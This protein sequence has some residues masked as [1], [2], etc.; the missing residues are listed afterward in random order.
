MFIK[1]QLNIFTQVR[2]R[3]DHDNGPTGSLQQIVPHG[4]IVGL[5]LHGQEA[6]PRRRKNEGN[7]QGIVSLFRQPLHGHF[8][9]GDR[10]V[11]RAQTRSAR[12]K[13]QDSHF[14]LA[15]DRRRRKGHE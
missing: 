1:K 8:P 9:D 14:V 7:T 4:Q 3:T 15:R 2:A 13:R 5:L 10:A 11:D 6:I 12:S